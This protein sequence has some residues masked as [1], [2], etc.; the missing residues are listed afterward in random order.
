MPKPGTS[1]KKDMLIGQGSSV[2]EHACENISEQL[3]KYN[4][5]CYVSWHI[6]KLTTFSK[7]QIKVICDVKELHICHCY[8][9]NFYPFSAK[10]QILFL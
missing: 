2:G 10:L 3:T 8:K 4:L 6:L 5:K 9:C 1:H 7:W